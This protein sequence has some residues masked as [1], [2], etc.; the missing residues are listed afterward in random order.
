M[1][2]VKNMWPYKYQS[3]TVALFHFFPL[4]LF[5]PSHC[6]SLSPT[7]E[8]P[9][10]LPSTSDSEVI[11]SR[12][13]PESSPGDIAL[14]PGWSRST[15]R[16]AFF[17][18]NPLRFLATKLW[19]YSLR[20]SVLFQGFPHPISDNSALRLNLTPAVFSEL[21]VCRFGLSA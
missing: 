3:Q 12:Q 4:C 9:C 17:K 10:I 14:C 1:A 8:V 7:V 15:I 11:K 13:W 2:R 5:P 19:Q 6:L 16:I 21:R 18:K 20:C